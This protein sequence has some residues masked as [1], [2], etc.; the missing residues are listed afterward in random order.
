MS[1]AEKRE[2]EERKKYYEAETLRERGLT[3]CLIEFPDLVECLIEHHQVTA[4]DSK[5]R[6]WRRLAK[7][8]HWEEMGRNFGFFVRE[9]FA[10]PDEVDRG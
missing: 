8:N 10:D 5:G 7:E 3:G 6:V 2:H 4:V 9:T 1:K